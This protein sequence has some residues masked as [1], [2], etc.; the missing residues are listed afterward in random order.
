[1]FYSSTFAP[2]IERDARDNMMERVK[3]PE[4]KEDEV[5]RIQADIRIRPAVFRKINR[6][7]TSKKF[8][9]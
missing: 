8:G 4:G 1:M 9:R 5:G 6:K 2:A 3:D 7:K